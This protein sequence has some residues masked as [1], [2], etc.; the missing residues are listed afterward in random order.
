MK[1]IITESQHRL[2][3]EKN[4]FDNN[5]IKN[6]KRLREYIKILK[7]NYDLGFVKDEGGNYNK[8][9][10]II[11][12]FIIIHNFLNLEEK[13]SDL[14]K[15]SN[16]EL[17]KY[18]NLPNLES[19]QDVLKKFNDLY[20]INSKVRFSVE[21]FERSYFVSKPNNLD[22]EEFKELLISLMT[23]DDETQ[24]AIVYSDGDKI[25]I[26][27]SNGEVFDTFSELTLNK[28][29]QA[30]SRHVKK[31][32]IP[33]V[34]EGLEMPGSNSGRMVMKYENIKYLI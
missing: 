34:F 27:G 30:Y 25:Y 1:Y 29:A 17:N 8:F 18:L 26:V 21:T 28:I 7:K 4:G 16:K 3:I 32:E 9:D 11:K 22:S 23:I 14:I 20:D 12:Y 31:H 2:L 10:I 19:L 5:L 15:L 24:D 33:F 6:Q 13:Y